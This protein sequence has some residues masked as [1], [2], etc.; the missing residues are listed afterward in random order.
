MA[1]SLGDRRAEAHAPTRLMDSA[2]IA[3]N[4]ATALALADHGVAIAREIGDVQLLGE[5][6]QG[7]AAGSRG[8]KQR[9]IRPRSWPAAASQATTC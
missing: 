1:R 7:L 6:L 5:Q 4:I 2:Y 9:R 8:K 3:G